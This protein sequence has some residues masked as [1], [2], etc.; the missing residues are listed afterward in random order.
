MILLV[1]WPL[2]GQTEFEDV[3][4]GIKSARVRRF[5]QVYRSSMRRL[6]HQEY[7]KSEEFRKAKGLR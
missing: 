3:S 1:H 6:L 4:S 5:D 2:V 7:L